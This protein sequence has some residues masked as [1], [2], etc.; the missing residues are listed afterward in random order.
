MAERLIKYQ[1][2]TEEQL[3]RDIFEF[4]WTQYD[5]GRMTREDFIINVEDEVE[6][7]ENGKE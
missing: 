2:M 4:Y 7:I 3:I 6:K 5:Q 1:E